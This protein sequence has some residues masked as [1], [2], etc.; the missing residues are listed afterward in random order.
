LQKKGL[1]AENIDKI[2]GQ[3]AAKHNYIVQLTRKLAILNK[4]RPKGQKTDAFAEFFNTYFTSNEVGNAR[5]KIMTDLDYYLEA[6]DPYL[7]GSGAGLLP[8]PE[9]AKWLRRVEQRKTTLGFFMWLEGEA[10][11]NAK[12]GRNVPLLKPLTGIITEIS[13]N[14]YLNI[15]KLPTGCY[16]FVVTKS[17]KFYFTPAEIGVK[18][19]G[20]SQGKPVAFAGEIAI[21]NGQIV[22][23]N[24]HSGHFRAST[25]FLL[26]ALDILKKAK[27]INGGYFVLSFNNLYDITKPGDASLFTYYADQEIP[28]RGKNVYEH[29]SVLPKGLE[30]LLQDGTLTGEVFITKTDDD[31]FYISSVNKY[32][33]YERRYQRLFARY[34]NGKR[35]QYT[36]QAVIENKKIIEINSDLPCELAVSFSELQ[37]AYKDFQSY[38]LVPAGKEPINIVDKKRRMSEFA[39][40]F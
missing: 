6:F 12:F 10:K 31:M 26:F 36:V 32:Y 7:K 27:C 1:S 25:D 5:T 20:L 2:F 35:R 39:Y 22:A 15:L 33:S 37:L 28:A 19:I 4:E 38:S 24:N 13:P 16:D 34:P 11:R 40:C 23:I 9:Y 30:T 18:H 29:N 3:A 17:G 21:S 14:N 8:D